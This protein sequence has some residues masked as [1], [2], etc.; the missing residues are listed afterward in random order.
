MHALRYQLM[1]LPAK[2]RQQLHPSTSTRSVCGSSL[3]HKTHVTPGNDCASLALTTH[4]PR[5]MFACR[6]EAHQNPG[7]IYYLHLPFPTSEIFRTLYHRKELLM[8]ILGA[9]LVCARGGCGHALVDAVACSQLV[10]RSWISR[11]AQCP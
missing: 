6:I 5:P 1:L 9:D 7:L 10:T 8:G 4:S 3:P 11:M 2:L